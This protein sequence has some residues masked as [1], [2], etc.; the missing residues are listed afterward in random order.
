MVQVRAV[1][2]SWRTAASSPC[3]DLPFAEIDDMD[4][5]ITDRRLDPR[6]SRRSGRGIEVEQA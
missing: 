2:S 5:V 6:S 3:V 4:L 1:V